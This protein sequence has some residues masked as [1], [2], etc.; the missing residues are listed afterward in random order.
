MVTDAPNKGAQEGEGREGAVQEEEIQ[1]QEEQ[2]EPKAGTSRRGYWPG[3]F[4]KEETILFVSF[5]VL[6][7]T[8]KIMQAAQIHWLY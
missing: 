8:E 5:L 7:R 4:L 2:D 6:P 3:N 1:K